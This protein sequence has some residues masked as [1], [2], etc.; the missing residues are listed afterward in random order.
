MDSFDLSTDSSFLD[1]SW[2]FPQP[3]SV[4]QRYSSGLVFSANAQP[5]PERMC[6][7]KRGDNHLQVYRAQCLLNRYIGGHFGPEWVQGNGKRWPFLLEDGLLNSDTESALRHFQDDWSLPLSGCLCPK[8]R[9]LL[10]PLL[11][12]R[13]TVLRKRL[14][15]PKLCWPQ[16]Y[17]SGAWG[18]G[19][20]P[21]GSSSPSNNAKKNSK[22][23][24]RPVKP[25]TQGAGNVGQGDDDDKPWTLTLTPNWGFGASGPLWTSKSGTGGYVKPDSL[26]VDQKT[27][28]DLSL[29]T[30]LALG[31]GKLKLTIGGE[32]DV[33]LDKDHA[34]KAT[35][36][37]NFQV[38]ADD[39]IK[40]DY[41][42]LSPFLK[43]SP[44]W[45]KD[46]NAWK[47]S[48]VLKA[49]VEIDA[50][51]KNLLHLDKAFKGLKLEGD[52]SSGVQIPGDSSTGAKAIVPLEG[53]LN[54]T[55]DLPIH[56][57]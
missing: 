32:Y 26:E 56:M 21:S 52:I 4:C 30:S 22:P 46:G 35:I 3:M 9:A 57:F 13:G 24:E 49:G 11:R 55:W 38:Q 20:G 15:F 39:L 28:I 47:D 37:A 54:L 43:Y 5:N 40:N 29:P 23:P 19:A 50:D 48:S 8:T 51:L 53:N 18:G 41:V 7:Y 33:P 25:D 17:S 10:P 14:R 45:Q 2:F 6:W 16:G 27:E 42:S 34:G 44:Q 12:L 31:M 1:T 36:A